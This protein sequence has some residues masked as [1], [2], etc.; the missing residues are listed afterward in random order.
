M[1][2]LKDK[3]VRV[4]YLDQSDIESFGFIIS[5]EDPLMGEALLF[6]KEWYK[7]TAP[8]KL[9]FLT[10]T[11]GVRIAFPSIKKSDSIHWEYGYKFR[12]TIK[13]KSELNILLKMIGVIKDE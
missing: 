9:L 11:Y 2:D 6:H 7:E 1:S 10:E 4:K 3:L 12:G 8:I 13:N 5:D